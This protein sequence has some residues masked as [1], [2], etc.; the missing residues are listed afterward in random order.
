MVLKKDI[1]KDSVRKVVAEAELI[2]RS[3]KKAVRHRNPVTQ[4]KMEVEKKLRVQ[5][6]LEVLEIV[7]VFI[8]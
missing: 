2:I 3:E 1:S 6:S 5:Y 7:R 8:R 4:K